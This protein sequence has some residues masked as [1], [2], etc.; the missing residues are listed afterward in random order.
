MDPQLE[1]SVR[2]FLVDTAGID[3]A[4][5]ADPAR[6]VTD[7]GLDSLGIVELLFDVEDRFGVRVDD[8][9]TIKDFTVAQLVAF[10][11]ERMASQPAAAHA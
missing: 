1:Q 7:L 6:K 2:E 3:A 8:P 11:G 4:L 10:F 5:I 9:A